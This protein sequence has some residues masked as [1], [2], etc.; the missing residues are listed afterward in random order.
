MKTSARPTTLLLHGFGNGPPACN[1]TLT[2]IGLDLHPVDN[3]EHDCTSMPNLPRPSREGDTTITIW[4][5]TE[6]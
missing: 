3:D 6:A 1:K 4:P 5:V 2:L